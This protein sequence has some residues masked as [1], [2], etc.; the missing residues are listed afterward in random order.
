MVYDVRPVVRGVWE[1]LWAQVGEGRKAD[2]RGEWGEKERTCCSGVS[3][4]A[5]RRANVSTGGR[6]G[7]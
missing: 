4:P 3:V 6:E 2:R 7:S 5:M 1:V